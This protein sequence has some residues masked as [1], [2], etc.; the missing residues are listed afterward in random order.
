MVKSSEK[1]NLIYIAGTQ[2]SGSTILGLISSLHSKIAY[3]GEVNR[4]Q[5]VISSKGQRNKCICKKLLLQCPFWI[6][7]LEGVDPF[8]QPVPQLGFFATS[9]LTSIQ[10]KHIPH[11][12]KAQTFK[13]SQPLIEI[14]GQNN[15]KFFKTFLDITEAQ[16]G[17]RPNW[18]IDSSKNPCRLFWLIKSNLF[19]IKVVHIV[20]N[21]CAYVYST[22]KRQAHKK[23]AG[24][25]LY[26]TIRKSL[27]WMLK[28]NLFSLVA[29]RHLEPSNYILIK[30]EDMAA[31]PKE[32]FKKVFKAIG[33][34]FKEEFVTNFRNSIRHTIGG[35]YSRFETRPIEL[36]EVW[37]KFLPKG[38]QRITQVITAGYR[39]RYGY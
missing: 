4:W 16:T 27:G 12:Y 2:Y 32:C 10:L 14:Y 29:D 11:F 25:R 17:T 24:K 5:S 6:E 28:N 1:I 9:M 38:N 13:K 33:C 3:C 7:M 31:N 19:N 8:K 36:D 39:R 21:P 30:Y 20:K 22:L 15:Y 26:L 35:S 34:E 18:L 23:F 37:H